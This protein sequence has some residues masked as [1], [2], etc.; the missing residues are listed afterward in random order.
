M[1]LEQWLA[2]LSA[3][4]GTVLVEPFVV[5]QV[6]HERPGRGRRRRLPR[7]TTAAL[8]GLLIAAPIVDTRTTA[9][10]ANTSSST[11]ARRATIST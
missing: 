2:A 1:D 6:L 3:E 10:S 7:H 5:A 8:R 4:L 9:D 11:S